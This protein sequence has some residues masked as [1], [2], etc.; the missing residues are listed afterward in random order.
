MSVTYSDSMGMEVGMGRT[1][2]IFRAADRP[3]FMYNDVR[4]PLAAEEKM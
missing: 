3:V 2:Y 4:M 1:L